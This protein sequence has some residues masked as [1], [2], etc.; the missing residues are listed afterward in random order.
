MMNQ[1]LLVNA[2]VKKDKEHKI[3][4]KKK[5]VD[6]EIYSVEENIV[7]SKLVSITKY[8]IKFKITAVK[9]VVPEFF[10]ICPVKNMSIY[11]IKSSRIVYSKCLLQCLSF[12]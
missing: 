10:Y 5:P 6:E 1:L 12:M 8:F 3:Q 9:L 11:A 2:Q 4:E 7:L